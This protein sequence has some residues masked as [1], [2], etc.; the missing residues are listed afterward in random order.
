MFDFVGQGSDPM[1]TE[2]D[3]VSI[4]D[5]ACLNRA[6]VI[7][8]TNTKGAFSLNSINIGPRATL[9]SWS[10]IMAGAVLEREGRLL[11]HTL[12]LVGDSVESGVIWQGW[13]PRLMLA[14]NECAILARTQ[15]M[16]DDRPCSHSNVS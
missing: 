8:H 3:L 10:R 15:S 5:E 13:P 11:E 6:F 12:A 14:T 16:H 2:P 7:C 9:R 1:M 4:G